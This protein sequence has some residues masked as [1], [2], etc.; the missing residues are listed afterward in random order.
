MVS[1]GSSGISIE[2]ENYDGDV[3]LAAPLEGSANDLLRDTFRVNV[4][5]AEVDGVLIGQLVP[6]AVR[7]DH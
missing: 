1:E 2:F 4:V 5:M 3:V 6:H 7:G